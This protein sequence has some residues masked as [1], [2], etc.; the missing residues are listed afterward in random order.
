[1]Y[2][3]IR[4]V[5]PLC[6]LA[7]ATAGIASA[8]EIAADKKLPASLLKK[9]APQNGEEIRSDCPRLGSI[10]LTGESGQVFGGYG[11]NTWRGYA[12][13]LV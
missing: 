7:M 10:R 2:R 8:Q 11:G 13:E 1:M 5:L 12:G 6:A 9:V 4:R 3:L